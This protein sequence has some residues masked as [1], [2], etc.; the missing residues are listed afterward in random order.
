MQLS[1]LC[2]GDVITKIEGKSIGEVLQPRLKYI[3]AS[4]YPA[5]LRKASGP[6]LP[7]NI[8]NGSTMAVT[9]TYE[10]D[11]RV[12]NAVIKRN[13]PGLLTQKKKEK[14]PP[15]RLINQEIGYADLGAMSGKNA[16]A[17]MAA[18][19]NTKGM[20]IDLRKNKNHTAS[21]SILK[22]MHHKRVPFARVEYPDLSYPG[23]L[24]QKNAWKAGRNN[25]DYYKGKV[26]VLFDETTQ[27]TGEF[28]CMAFQSLSNVVSIG[29]RTAGAAG[30]IT[31]IYL[32]G[33]YLTAITGLG[34]YYP[35][36]REVQPFGI[37]PDIEVKQTIEGLRQGKD[38]VLERALSYIQTGQ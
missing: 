2:R 34:V 27:S 17:M 15:W 26:V 28:A 11:G 9:I 29:S 25:K 1:G 21:H 12:Q 4:H 22:R 36:G 32:P 18:F 37:K 24:R 7:Y 38:E 19:K 10:R 30:N 35:D 14:S 33:G 31:R 8:F 20:I 16:E 5:Q 13:L 3:V 23:L 6:F